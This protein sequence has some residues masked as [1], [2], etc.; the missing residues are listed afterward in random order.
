MEGVSNGR[1]IDM[2]K[3]EGIQ[4]ACIYVT[5]LQSDT[6]TLKIGH[7]TLFKDLDRLFK[8]FQNLN[9]SKA[10]VKGKQNLDRFLEQSYSMPV[11]KSKS[12]DTCD[13]SLPAQSEAFTKTFH[14]AD[15]ADLKSEVFET[16]ALK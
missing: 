10:R 16:V 13:K 12:S 3:H 9:K 7:E 8:K 1:L 15:S 6:C 11:P 14:A 5:K 2:I 4:S